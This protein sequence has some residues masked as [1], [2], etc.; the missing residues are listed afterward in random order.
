MS[1]RKRIVGCLVLALVL[2]AT[3]PLASARP[4]RMGNLPDK[5][6]KFGCGTCHANPAGGGQRNAFGQ[7]YEKIGLKGGDKYT[8]E[9]GLWILIKMN[10]PTIRNL[11]VAAILGIRS[12][13]L[14]NRNG[15]FPGVDQRKMKKATLYTTV[16]VAL[17]VPG[18]AWVST[19]MPGLPWS[20]Y[21]YEVGRLLALLGFVLVFFQYVLSSKAGWIERWIAGSL[22]KAHRKWD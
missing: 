16:A 3:I 10:S 7:D 19:L 8:Q 2:F 22:F 4:F 11:P 6:S 13:S 21:L 18:A 9:L 14:R 5:G 12:R 20:V 15:S 17:A 1:L